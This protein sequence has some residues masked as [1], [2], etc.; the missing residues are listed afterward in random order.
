MIKHFEEF[1]KKSH[2]IISLLNKTLEEENKN[3]KLLLKEFKQNCEKI[4]K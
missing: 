3:V 4:K 1:M 2:K